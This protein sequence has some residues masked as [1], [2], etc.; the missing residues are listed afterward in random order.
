MLINGV[1]VDPRHFVT[2]NREFMELLKKYNIQSVTITRDVERREIEAFRDLLY[3]RSKED[4]IDPGYWDRHLDDQRIEH[5][6]VDQRVYVVAGSETGPGD[7]GAP[8]EAGEREPEREEEEFETAIPP[9]AFDSEVEDHLLERME[10]ALVGDGDEPLDDF[11]REVLRLLESGAPRE[12]EVGEELL[13]EFMK[14]LRALHDRARILSITERLT[15]RLDRKIPDRAF[16]PIARVLA[17]GTREFIKR[18]NYQVASRIVHFLGYKES[19][20]GETR[21]VT[22]EARRA[23]NDV[24]RSGA[25]DLIIADLI[26]EEPQR[27]GEAREV[28]LGFNDLVVDPLIRVVKES[29]DYRTRKFTSLILHELGDRAVRQLKRELNESTV[30]EE[31]RRI[32]GILDTFPDDFGDQ[33]LSA[34]CHTNPSIRAEAARLLRKVRGDIHRILLDVL[35]STD[36]PA[37]AEAMIQ[38]GRIKS[39]EAVGP[40]LDKLAGDRASDVQLYEGCM[41]LGRI[42]DSRA[43]EFLRGILAD[44]RFPFLKKRRASKVRFAAAWALAQIASPEAI[45]ALKRVRR[46][47]DSDI[48][49]LATRTVKS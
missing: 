2:G 8:A 30:D 20:E 48:R 16:G 36:G 18:G 49:A 42:G 31:Y 35:K 45:D 3:E 43:V 25:F 24:I 28:L 7:G 26:S 15:S 29:D 37:A 33:L 1:K 34:L 38:L 32:L 27:Q 12:K 23:L 6:S 13:G 11:L 39:T 9:G 41:A 40:I 22:R 14:K 47:R 10:E 4:T 5:L 17:E 19:G 44:A 21:E 46:D